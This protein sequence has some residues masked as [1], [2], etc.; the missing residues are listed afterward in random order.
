MVIVSGLVVTCKSD[1]FNVF[2]PPAG[3]TCA[4]W[5]SDFVTTF[6]GYLDNPQDTTG[7]RYCQYE[8]CDFTLSF[9]AVF[10]LTIDAVDG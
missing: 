1:E 4:N 6:G 3:Q 9:F 7:C 10:L 2:N 8:V 5:A